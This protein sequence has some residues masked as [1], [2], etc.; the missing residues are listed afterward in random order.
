MDRTQRYDNQHSP[1]WPIGRQTRHHTVDL[2]NLAS[3]HLQG[4][5]DTKAHRDYEAIKV[6][7]VFVEVK[8][9]K[10]SSLRWNT[11]NSFRTKGGAVS[12]ASGDRGQRGPSGIG[13]EGPQG[14]P[15]RRGSDSRTQITDNVLKSF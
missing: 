6:T 3:L 7:K 12:G 4:V 1:T 14:H 15:G 13:R 8:A 2:R 5:E 9:T 10:V 11:S